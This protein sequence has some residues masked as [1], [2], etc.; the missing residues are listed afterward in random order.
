MPNSALVS[1]VK[2]VTLGLSRSDTLNVV[3]V[4]MLL[5]ELSFAKILTIYVPRLVRFVEERLRLLT[6]TDD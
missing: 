3:F 5:P 6:A 1:L 2:I 4:L